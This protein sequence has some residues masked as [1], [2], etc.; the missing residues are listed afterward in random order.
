[1]QSNRR[2]VIVGNDPLCGVHDG[3]SWRF[4]GDPLGGTDERVDLG[5]FWEMVC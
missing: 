1:V 5:D 2:Y 3:V 4:T